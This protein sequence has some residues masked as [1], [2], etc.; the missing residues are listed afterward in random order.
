M[1]ARTLSRGAVSTL[2]VLTLTSMSIAQLSGNYTI[3][4]KGSGS[5][6]YATI[7]AAVSALGAGVSGPVVFNVASTTFKESV[8]IN[9]VSGVS[10]SVTVTFIASGAGAVIDASGQ[11]D[12]L[13]INSPA[14]YLTF[15]NLKVRNASRYGLNVAG[16][17]SNRCRWLQF[18]NCEFEV[19]ASSSS[20]LRAAYLYYP[21]DTIFRNTKFLG[22][23]YPLYTQQTNRCLYDTCEFDGKKQATRLTS[24]YN[25]NDS[26]NCYINCFFHDAGPSGYGVYVN[27]SQY[28]IMFWNNT[29]IVKSSNAAVLLGGCCAWSRCNSFRNNIVVQQGTGPAMVYGMSGVLDYNDLDHNC[30][31]APNATNGTVQTEG[32]LFQGTLA[33]WKAILKLPGLKWFPPGGG[34]S[35]DQNS[36]EA[37][38]VLVSATAPY[39]IHLNGLSPCV[40]GGTPNYVAGGWVSFPPPSHP[41]LPSSVTLD[42][43][44]QARGNTPDIG[45]DEVTITL[46]GTG[47]GLPGSSIMLTLGATPDAGLPYQMGSSLGNGPIPIDTRTLGLSPDA[48]LLLSATSALPTVFQNYAGVLD[49]KG[50]AAA[51]LNIP[52]I[53]ALKGTRIYT[54]FVTLRATAPSGISNISNTFLFTVQ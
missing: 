25:S 44:G 11:Q 45:A 54:A 52:K 19:A 4:P 41:F 8:S 3:D 53:P 35:W 10:S 48:L 9:A 12:G 24:L 30:Y 28:G 20:S 39:D 18:L 14:S 29:I 46:V 38:P 36:I 43:E 2:L 23:G 21:D 33:A 50:T 16:S 5:R 7:G 15:D 51:K 13:T 6:N 40:N 42:F 1:Q 31:Y 49:A 47:S 32:G 26:D 34:T 17:S 22:G 37:D 27:A